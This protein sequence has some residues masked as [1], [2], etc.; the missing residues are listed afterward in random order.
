MKQISEKVFQIGL[1]PVN[2]F[3]IE[4]NGLTL[5]DTGFP[6]STDKIFAAIKKGGKAPEDIQRIILTHSHPDH[7]GSVA[8]IKKRLDIPVLAHY[9]DAALLEKGE[10]GR[11]PRVLGPGFLNFMLYHIFIKNGATSVEPVTF[12]GKL[13]DNDVIDIAGGV[14]VIQ[15]PGHSLGQIV[16]LVKNDGVLI[17]ADLCANFFGLGLS[18]VSED[19]Q[20]SVES[21]GKVSKFAFDKAVFGHGDPLMKDANKK[22]NAFYNKLKSN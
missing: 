1:G 18:T 21:I 5:V 12:E 17:A 9:E 8:E 11:Y 6:G 19:Q 20:L 3:L 16:L 2:V 22:L 7:S 4:D 10:V 13:K 15:A 14:Q